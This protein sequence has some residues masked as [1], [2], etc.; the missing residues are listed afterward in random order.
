MVLL[1]REPAALTAEFHSLARVPPEVEWFANLDNTHTP[2]PGERGEGFHALRR[3][4][5]SARIP[6]SP[7]RGAR[8][9][10]PVLGAS[11]PHPQ[12]SVLKSGANMAV[13]DNF[14]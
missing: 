13:G 2:A 8:E 14:P 3:H 1:L 11:L 10:W 9:S 5:A 7:L 6:F 4:L 12:R